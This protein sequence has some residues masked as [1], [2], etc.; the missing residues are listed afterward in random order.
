MNF[1]LYGAQL[2]HLYLM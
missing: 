1:H 2:S